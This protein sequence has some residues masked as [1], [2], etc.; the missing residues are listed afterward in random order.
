M[1]LETAFAL[2]S[3]ILG[4]AVALAFPALLR[5][6]KLIALPPIPSGY[7]ANDED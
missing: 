2:F 5:V 7:G 1:E 3:V 4:G 6:L